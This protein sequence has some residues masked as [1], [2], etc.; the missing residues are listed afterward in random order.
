MVHQSEHQETMSAELWYTLSHIYDVGKT[1]IYTIPYLSSQQTGRGMH[2]IAH[3]ARSPKPMAKTEK[4]EE[5][6]K[7][8]RLAAHAA[9][10]EPVRDKPQP[11]WCIQDMWPESGLYTE[12]H[13]LRLTGWLRNH[14]VQKSNHQ[15]NSC[16]SHFTPL[17]TPY[18][19]IKHRQLPHP[20]N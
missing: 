2:N 15:C 18:Y 19:K 5:A 8:A 4:D 7:S 14:T 20:T 10:K 13:W 3:G 17:S 16:V 6:S 9:D 12:Y 11:R 1:V